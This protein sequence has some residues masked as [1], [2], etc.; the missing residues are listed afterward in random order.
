M[1]RTNILL[2]ALIL[3]IIA[4]TGWAAD[5]FGE[6][7][8][9]KIIA[10]EEKLGKAIDGLFD[11]SDKG[12]EKFEKSVSTGLDK[13]GKAIDTFAK[14]VERIFKDF[15]KTASSNEAT[16]SSQV[17]EVIQSVSTAAGRTERKT[18]YTKGEVGEAAKDFW[19]SLKNLAS[20]F[21]KWAKAF[22]AQ[23]TGP[24]EDEAP[25][26]NAINKVKTDFQRWRMGNAWEAFSSS[27]GEMFGAIGRFAKNL[28]NK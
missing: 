15:K 26:T 1:N 25:V 17:D 9:I 16:V 12:V 14:D 18:G 10:Q 28:F 4:N 7:I 19:G 21:G 5:P 20:A 24:G 2:T 8:K 27:T 13:A 6:N 3:V 22:W 11:T 23:I